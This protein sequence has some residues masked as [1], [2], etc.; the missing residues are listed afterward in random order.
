MLYKFYLDNKVRRK[1]KNNS[2]L[3]STFELGKLLYERTDFQLAIPTLKNASKNYHSESDF[4][5]YLKCLNLLLH[6]YNEQESL[7]KIDETKEDLQEVALKKGLEIS[8]EVHYTLGLCA[9]YKEQ[10]KISLDQFEKSL[11][12][13]LSQNKKETYLLCYNGFISCLHKA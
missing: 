12:L 10:H 8:P 4:S 3:E 1:L 13:A 11:T 6:I 9:L 7:D 2:T 5:S